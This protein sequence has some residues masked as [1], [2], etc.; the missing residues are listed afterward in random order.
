MKFVECNFRHI[1]PV[2]ST[3]ENPMMLALWNAKEESGIRPDQP[4]AW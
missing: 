2:H 4:F 3:M 1:P